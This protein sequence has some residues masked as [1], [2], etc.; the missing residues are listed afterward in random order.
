[1][2]II[3]ANGKFLSTPEAVRLQGF[4][5]R[6]RY[7]YYCKIEV[8]LMGIGDPERAV[9]QASLFLSAV[10]PEIMAC[11]PDW[12]RVSSGSDADESAGPVVLNPERR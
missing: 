12:D 4:D 6:D 10:M 2:N 11:L 3:A 1:M 8:G 7:S 5:P 9:E